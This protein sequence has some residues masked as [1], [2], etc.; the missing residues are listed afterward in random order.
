MAA[1]TQVAAAW[2]VLSVL[3]V[4]SSVVALTQPSVE[5][6]WHQY[7]AAHDAVV[8]TSSYSK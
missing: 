1:S 3:P 8:A 2:K 7:L 4:I 6:T 5:Y